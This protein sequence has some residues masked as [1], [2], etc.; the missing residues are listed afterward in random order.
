MQAAD[1]CF[2]PPMKAVLRYALAGYVAVGFV[3]TIYDGVCLHGV[4]GILG[5]EQ[6]MRD[7]VFAYR[8]LLWPMRLF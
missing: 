6:D 5:G 8:N 1:G 4:L 2:C 7:M 3:H